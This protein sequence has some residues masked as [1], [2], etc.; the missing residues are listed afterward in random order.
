MSGTKTFVVQEGHQ[1]SVSREERGHQ[2]TVIEKGHQP[3]QVV[4]TS[5]STPPPISSFQTVVISPQKSE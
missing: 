4:T 2:P 3:K 1:P 5:L